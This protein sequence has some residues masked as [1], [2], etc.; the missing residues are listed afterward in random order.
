MASATVPATIGGVHADLLV[1]Y[2]HSAPTDAELKVELLV[3]QSWF[4]AFNGNVA[5]SAAFVA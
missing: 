4:V 2:P 3:I 5:V 1:I